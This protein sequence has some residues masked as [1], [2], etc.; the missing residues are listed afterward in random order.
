MRILY[1]INSSLC[2][3]LM[4]LLTWK[5]RDV[6]ILISFQLLSVVI[7]L[8]VSSPLHIEL[9]CSSCIHIELRFLSLINVC[10][11]NPSPVLGQEQQ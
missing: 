6:V 9:C 1:E 4:L 2:F 7:L 10:F 5:E 11:H 8:L 3:S